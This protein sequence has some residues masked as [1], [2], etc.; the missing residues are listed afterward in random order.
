MVPTGETTGGQ[1]VIRMVRDGQPRRLR[2]AHLTP[3]GRVRSGIAGDGV[4]EDC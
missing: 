3:P 4:G 2:R 1:T